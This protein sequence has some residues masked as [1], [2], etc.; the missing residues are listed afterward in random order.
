MSAVQW[1][2]HVLLFSDVHVKE[3]QYMKNILQ[4]NSI[5]QHTYKINTSTKKNG[6]NLVI[7]L[8]LQGHIVFNYP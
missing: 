4:V 6:L 1:P 3:K 8:I 5:L 7:L 2:V